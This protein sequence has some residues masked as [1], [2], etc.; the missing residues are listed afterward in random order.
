M[1]EIACRAGP[2]VRDL[3]NASAPALRDD[4]G[5]EINFVMRRTNARTEMRN[6]TLR[7]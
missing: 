3:E 2:T 6:D 7:L 4:F 5:G 1:L